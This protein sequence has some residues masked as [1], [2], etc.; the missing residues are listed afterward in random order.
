MS[1]LTKKV[2]LLVMFGIAFT[3]VIGVL[4]WADVAASEQVELDCDESEEWCRAIKRWNS[5]DWFEYNCEQGTLPQIGA[6]NLSKRVLGKGT[7]G[8]AAG[9]G[10]V[11]QYPTSKLIPED[12]KPL[13]D[14]YIYLHPDSKLGFGLY[15]VRVGVTAKKGI[16]PG[17]VEAVLRCDS[18][19]YEAVER[20]EQ[21][22]LRLGM[23][24]HLVLIH[25][26][27]G[28]PEARY[29]IQRKCLGSVDGCLETVVEGVHF[30][31]PDGGEIAKYIR[32]VGD[33]AETT[34]E[35]PPEL[36]A[37]ARDILDLVFSVFASLLGR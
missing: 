8:K 28:L 10:T 4:L 32:S 21:T 11:V 23:G 1:T 16:S 30:E 5:L 18:T 15:C 20:C 26:E 13:Y 29:T 17:T 19:S 12:P 34:F 35:R 22:E 7:L 33:G 31:P 24:S 3:V 14:P 2:I 37:E 9:W 25:D 6:N 27:Y 36:C